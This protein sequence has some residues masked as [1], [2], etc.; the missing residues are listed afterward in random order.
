MTW[1]V[2]VYRVH[3]GEIT[4][5]DFFRS[6]RKWF[7][8]IAEEMKRFDSA[9]VDVDDIAQEGMIAAFNA[10]NSWRSDGDAL[11]S[12]IVHNVRFITN[13]AATRSDYAMRERTSRASL[14]AE[15][16]KTAD[17]YHEDADPVVIDEAT[18]EFEGIEKEVVAGIARGYSLRTISVLLLLYRSEEYKIKTARAAVH[19]VRYASRRILATQQHQGRTAC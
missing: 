14:I 6:H 10:F 12:W 11:D 16:F 13:N 19:K 3:N 8:K 4:L 15:H 7:Y 2:D 17:T 9:S 18:Q 1:R 5:E